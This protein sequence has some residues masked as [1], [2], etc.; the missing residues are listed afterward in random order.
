VNTETKLLLLTEAFEVQNFLRVTLKTDGDNKRSQAAIAR[1]GAQFEGTLRS[2]RM[3]AD[4]TSRDSMYY[5]ILST[6]WPQV[7][8][9]LQGALS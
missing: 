9:T 2:H 7:K 6:E 8:A 1:I 4:G 5:S 3:R